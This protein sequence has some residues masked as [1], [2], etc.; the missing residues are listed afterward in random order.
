MAIY[1]GPVGNHYD[2]FGTGNPIARRLM[3][4]F[5]HSFEELFQQTSGT[6]ILEIGC[7]EGH[8]L[9]AMQ[10]QRS[11]Q[12]TAFDVEIPILHEARQRVPDARI[13]LMDAHQIAHPAQ[14]F[15]VVIACEV[16]EH[17]YDPA[18]VLAEAA[19]VSRGYAVFSVPREPLWRVL[20][21]ARGKYWAE[22]GNTPGHIQH[23]SSAEFAALVGRYFEVIAV[24][25]PLPWTMLLCKRRV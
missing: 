8:M 23:W 3:A 11:V 5:M 24:R 1:Q 2:K 6:A 13:T 17:V 20:N 18:R 14:A 19:R 10:Q 7:G 4:G 21:M 15:D 25:Q 22:W 12:L 9:A 16:L